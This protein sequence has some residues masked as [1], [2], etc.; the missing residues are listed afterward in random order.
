VAAVERNLESVQLQIN[1]AFREVDEK[2]LEAKA[3]VDAERGE[4][5]SETSAMRTKLESFATGGIYLSMMGTA[6]IV[7][8]TILSTIP[9]ELY[10]FLER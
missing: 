7:V 3:M 1:Q 2:H 4:R 9:A 8:G 6:W 5:R 10:C